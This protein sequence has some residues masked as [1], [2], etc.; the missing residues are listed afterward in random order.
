MSSAGRDRMSG[1]YRLWGRP[2]LASGQ[3]SLTPKWV[4]FRWRG[5]PTAQASPRAESLYRNGALRPYPAPA[6]T[7]P[8]R[9]PAAIAR[10]ISTKAMSGLD[11]GA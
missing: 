7:Q 5:M 1:M 2:R 3:I 6:I 9:M 4:H 11:R 8:K 10:S